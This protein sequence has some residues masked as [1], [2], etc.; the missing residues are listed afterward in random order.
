MGDGNQKMSLNNLVV[1][2]MPSLRMLTID[3]RS[4]D[5]ERRA[6]GNPPERVRRSIGIVT[7]NVDVE[8]KTKTN[9]TDPLVSRSIVGSGQQGKTLALKKT[10]R[11]G[12]NVENV[13]FDL[14]LNLCC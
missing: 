1:V 4:R 10:R 8:M 14:F 9:L 2:G 6:T 3:I 13:I 7:Q 11:E 5:T 12:V